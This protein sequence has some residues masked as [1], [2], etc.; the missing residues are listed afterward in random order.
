MALD[1][2]AIFKTTYNQGIADGLA[3]A[4]ATAAAQAA[5]ADCL[6]SQSVAQPTSTPIISVAGSR[7]ADAGPVRPKTR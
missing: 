3:V 1:C 2:Y 6:T 5:M 4:V 7:I